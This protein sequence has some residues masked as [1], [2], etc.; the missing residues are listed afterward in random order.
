MKEFVLATLFI[1]SAADPSQCD[2][3]EMQVEAKM[4]KLGVY[5]AKVASGGDWMPVNMYIKCKN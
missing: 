2:H 1:C 4:C 5:E 3:K